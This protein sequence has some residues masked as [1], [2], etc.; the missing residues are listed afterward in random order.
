MATINSFAQSA[1]LVLLFAMPL[2]AFAL[3]STKQS[4]IW[5]ILTVVFEAALLIVSLTTLNS[6]I[7]SGNYPKATGMEGLALIVMPVMYFVSIMISLA[8]FGI[9]DRFVARR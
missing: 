8:A 1:F 2:L 5:L 9:A 3:G 4:I 7:N 6:L